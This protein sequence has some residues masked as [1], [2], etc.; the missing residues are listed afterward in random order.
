MMKVEEQAID[1]EIK[2]E[3]DEDVHSVFSPLQKRLIVLTASTAALL[4]PLSSNIYLPALNLIASDLHVSNSLINL[5][6]TSYLVCATNTGC[7]GELKKENRSF[8]L[9]HRCSWPASP[10]VLDDALLILHVLF[11]IWAPMWL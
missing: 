3:V 9:C 8:K 2:A 1:C 10:T 11:C 5:T 4:S 7:E 6:V